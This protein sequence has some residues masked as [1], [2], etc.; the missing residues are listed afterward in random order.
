MLDEK[1]F[2]FFKLIVF[3]LMPGDE[4]HFFWIAILSFEKKNFNNVLRN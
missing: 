2:L 4:T 3:Y 1:H